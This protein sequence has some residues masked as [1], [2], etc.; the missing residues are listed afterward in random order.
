[1]K[2]EVYYFDEPGF[3]NTQ[4]VLK[5]SKKRAEELGIKKI[6]VASV[7]GK[8]A[9]DALKVLKDKEIISVTYHAGFSRPNEIKLDVENKRILD[10]NGVP[11]IIATHALSGIERSISKTLGGYGPVELVAK[12]LKSLFGSGLKVCVEISVMAADAG[13][14]SVDEEII[15]IG[16][17]G[18]VGADTSCVIKP[19]NMNR[20]FDLKV[21]EIICIPRGH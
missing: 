10:E 20:F 5:L 15:A 9:V 14:V 7:T 18:G 2:R 3:K 12:V 19:A 1:M 16:G 21:R 6:V 11:I 4:E 8:T 13:L 17:S